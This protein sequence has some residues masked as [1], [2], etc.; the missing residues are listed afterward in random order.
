MLHKVTQYALS[1]QQ[2]MWY[3]QNPIGQVCLYMTSDVLSYQHIL[4]PFAKTALEATIS[5]QINMGAVSLSFVHVCKIARSSLF[6]YVGANYNH[7]LCHQHTFNELVHCLY[8]NCAKDSF[9]WK[10]G[11]TSHVHSGRLLQ[12]CELI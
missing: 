1:Q 6:Q 12:T 11:C 8:I 2:Y 5:L 10:N 9:V 7:D 4:E 3:N